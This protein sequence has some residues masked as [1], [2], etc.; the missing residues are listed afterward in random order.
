[1]EKRVWEIPQVITEVRHICTGLFLKAFLFF[2]L[3]FLLFKR[4]RIAA[5]L[6]ST[7]LQRRVY[8][9]KSK[10]IWGIPLLDMGNRTSCYGESTK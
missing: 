1:L 4:F 7:D 10:F 9:K 3:H 6:V 2:L 8:G 5:S